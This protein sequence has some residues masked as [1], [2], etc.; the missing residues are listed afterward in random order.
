[1]A[2]IKRNKNI[3]PSDAPSAAAV[4]AAKNNILT[5]K[6]E[7]G[8]AVDF[9]LID[10]FARKDVHYLLLVPV[11]KEEPDADDV[12]ILRQAQD[13]ESSYE[14]VEPESR[15]EILKVFAERVDFSQKVVG[16]MEDEIKQEPHN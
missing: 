5:M 3:N 7:D 6:D 4:N 15:G 8:N 16:K 9:H 14:E 13:D 11:E 1:M 12:L 2:I 10:S